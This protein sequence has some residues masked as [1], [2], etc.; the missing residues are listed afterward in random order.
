MAQSRA[1]GRVWNGKGSSG[2]ALPDSEGTWSWEAFAQHWEGF[3]SPSLS[4][5]SLRAPPDPILASA[6]YNHVFSC[7]PTPKPPNCHSTPYRLFL[8]RITEPSPNRVPSAL[9]GKPLQCW[10]MYGLSSVL[11]F[12]LLKERSSKRSVSLRCLSRKPVVPSSWGADSDELLPT[13]VKHI[14]KNVVTRR[15]Q[16]PLP[17]PPRRAMVHSLLIRDPHDF[18]NHSYHE[19]GNESCLSI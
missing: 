13:H 11:M 3:G 18:I 17:T 16:E 1:E 12:S 6:D 9:P 7:L 8:L 19:S 14:D 10:G 5:Q 2:A 4:S 15:W